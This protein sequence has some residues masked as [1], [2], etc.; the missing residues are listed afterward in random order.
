MAIALNDDN[1]NVEDLHGQ[2]RYV[3]NQEKIKQ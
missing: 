2:I 1:A 3:T